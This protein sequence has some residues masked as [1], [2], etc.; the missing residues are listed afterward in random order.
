[1]LNIYSVILVVYMLI[2]NLE[3]VFKLLVI[4]G[5]WKVGDF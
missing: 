2:L 3:N 4:F 1:M 5:G